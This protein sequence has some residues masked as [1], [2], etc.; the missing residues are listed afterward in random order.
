MTR[1]KSF[2]CIV[3]HINRESG[4]GVVTF[5]AEFRAL[6][7]ARADALLASANA[8]TLDENAFLKE[9]LIGWS[10]LSG[11]IN[12][13]FVYDAA[14]LAALRERY[15]GMVGSMVAAYAEAEAGR[16]GVQTS[17]RRK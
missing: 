4:A 6:K 2:S 16:T 8:G 5:T 14:N 11:G 12:A 13:E 15:P 7:R 10:G 9:T 3:R 1:S 17:G